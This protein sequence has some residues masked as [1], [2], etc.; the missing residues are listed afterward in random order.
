MK[1]TFHDNN[2]TRTRGKHLHSRVIKPIRDR[3]TISVTRCLYRSYFAVHFD[4]YSFLLST[5]VSSQTLKRIK[6]VITG[7]FFDDFGN[8]LICRTCLK[9]IHL[10]AKNWYRSSFKG[11]NFC[12]ESTDYLRIWLVF[13]FVVFFYLLLVIIFDLKSFS[14]S[15]MVLK[16][17]VK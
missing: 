13:F 3:L 14:S 17:K 6:I 16:I 1:Y 15:I 9:I 4:F 2:H 8:W 12:M 11:N 10:K 5:E 7:Q